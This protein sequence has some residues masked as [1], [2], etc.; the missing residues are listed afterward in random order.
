MPPPGDKDLWIAN[1]RSTS[2]P[3]PRRQGQSGSFF[4]S[5][6]NSR[7]VTLASLQK[8]TRR[9]HSSLPPCAKSDSAPFPNPHDCG[10]N[11]LTRADTS[12]SCV[13][14]TSQVRPSVPARAG[15]AGLRYPRR[16]GKP[17]R[18]RHLF[19]SDDERVAGLN[20]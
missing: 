14:G 9:S 20:A 18:G 16:R 15:E 19:V 3:R 7:S 13:A 12:P 5:T 6:S 10:S 8:L 1:R 2:V 11:R 17:S 4:T